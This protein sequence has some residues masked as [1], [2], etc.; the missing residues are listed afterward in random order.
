MT[1]IYNFLTSTA[2]LNGLC[3]AAF[4]VLVKRNNRR[5]NRVLAGAIVILAVD[6]GFSYLS[7]NGYDKTYPHLMGLHVPLNYLWWSLFYLYCALITSHIETFRKKHLW[8]FIGPVA[9]TLLLVPKFALSGSEKL[10]EFPTFIFGKE[11]ILRMAYG[12]LFS[13]LIIRALQRYAGRIRGFFSETEQ[14]DL[15]WLR[16]IVYTFTAYW[17]IGTIYTALVVSGGFSQSDG[18]IQFFHL[19]GVAIPF[20]W[21]V[22]VGYFALVQ[23]EVFE[24]T[25][26]MTRALDP[27][28]PKDTS[29]K[30]DKAFTDDETTLFAGMLK[31][32]MDEAKPHL[33]EDLTLPVLAEGVGLSLHDLSRL[34]NTRHQ[35]NFHAFINEHRV[36]EAKKQL[37]DPACAEKSILEIT[38]DAG[39]KSR[40]TFNTAFKKITGMTP[41]A[42]R[43]RN[44]E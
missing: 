19:V 20:G 29:E 2:V 32:H 14:L 8:I 36:N 10:S 27:A 41:S 7:K 4:L 44:R 22:M 42:Y 30:G 24:Q 37:A 16:S 15:K 12:W 28:P 43:S 35:K 6:L 23:P 31:T 33:N 34:I 26:E 21:I 11:Y 3:L 40:S 9:I 13:V 1:E 17:A 25:Q 5:P 18:V 38:C 39:F